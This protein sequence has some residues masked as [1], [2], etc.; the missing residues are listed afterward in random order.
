MS[1]FSQLTF[2]PAIPV[3]STVKVKN[4]ATVVATSNNIPAN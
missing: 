2:S 4:G 1:D 3:G